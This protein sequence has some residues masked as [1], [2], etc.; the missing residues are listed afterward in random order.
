[1]AKKIPV[2]CYSRVSGYFRPINQFNKGKLAEFRDRYPR[3][4]KE[5]LESLK[6]LKTKNNVTI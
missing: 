4:Q 3:M 2:E 5:V 1:M 6:N